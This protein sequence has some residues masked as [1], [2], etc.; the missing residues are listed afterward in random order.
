MMLLSKK[1]VYISH[2]YIVVCTESKL[3]SDFT[4]LGLL[5]RWEADLNVVHQNRRLNFD[6]D[7]KNLAQLSH[8]VATCQM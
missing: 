6:S 7:K 5:G 3:H 4:F 2:F 8:D 1:Y